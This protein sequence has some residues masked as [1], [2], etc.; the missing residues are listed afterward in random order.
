[1][2][3]SIEL[4]DKKS[5][6]HALIASSIS[7]ETLIPIKGIVEDI[8]FNEK[9]AYYDIRIIKFY[10]NIDFLKRVLIDRP[11]L[12]KFKGK[13]KSISIPKEIKTA[14]ALENWFSEKSSYR[15]CVEAPFV[16]RSKNEMVDLFNKIQEY[17][18]IQNLRTIRTS[19]M[20]PLYDGPFRMYSK[21]EFKERLRR[22]I[23]D[24]FTEDEFDRISDSI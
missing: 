10:D 17:L 5:I 11:F 21:I 8:H 16:T 4:I 14:A 7:P 18:I 22:M 23:I 1:M 3:Q 24:R 9:T 13:V 15:F 12:L 19:A 20:R 6:C 2:I